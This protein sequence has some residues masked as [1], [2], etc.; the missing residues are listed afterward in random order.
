MGWQ[1]SRSGNL[2]SVAQG[3]PDRGLAQS[4]DDIAR[5]VS[6][7]TLE[8]EMGPMCEKSFF[9]LLHQGA[10]VTQAD[11]DG[12]S[13]AF[14][15]LT[16]RLMPA[17]LVLRFV[18][19]ACSMRIL[20]EA[21][22]GDLVPGFSSSEDIAG[23]DAAAR[24]ASRA[25]KFTQQEV[26]DCLQWNQQKPQIPVAVA[27]LIQL[28]HG[29]VE[30]LRQLVGRHSPEAAEAM[31]PFA[32]QW[33]PKNVLKFVN[34]ALFVTGRKRAGGGAFTVDQALVEEAM[35]LL[36]HAGAFTWDVQADTSIAAG[37]VG[38]IHC[39]AHSFLHKLLVKEGA[40]MTVVDF[41]AAEA[42]RVPPAPALVASLERME[43][44]AISEE[45]G[46]RTFGQEWS[47]M[48]LEA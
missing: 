48:K 38:R 43:R 7:A 41:V 3:D 16:E 21:R 9:Q 13:Q 18:K 33:A 37:A 47:R 45:T 15:T 14:T 25:K 23:G 10:A 4:L 31:V 35:D 1:G 46:I 30:A 22:Y 34:I 12:A 32:R 11:V 5:S 44:Y 20:P 29:Y 27:H 40:L 2:L 17:A 19:H 8:L 39:P 36:S 42:A 6:A 26:L 28:V 24:L